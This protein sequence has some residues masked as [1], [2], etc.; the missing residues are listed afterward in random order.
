MERVGQHAWVT[1]QRWGQRFGDNELPVEAEEVFGDGVLGVLRARMVVYG[2]RRPKGLGGR[3]GQGPL[4]LGMLVGGEHVSSG[5][6][7]RRGV[8]GR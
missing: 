6:G 7:Q 2:H 8:G 1:R 3:A 4:C 5:E